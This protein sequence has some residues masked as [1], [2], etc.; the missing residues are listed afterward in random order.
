MVV[1]CLAAIAATWLLAAGVAQATVAPTRPDKDGTP[2]TVDDAMRMVLHAFDDV[3]ESNPAQAADGLD[4]A[5]HAPGFAGL[6]E[7]LRLQAISVAGLL[8]WEADRNEKAHELAVQATGFPEADGTSWMLRFSSAFS[9]GKFQDAGYSL[10]QFAKRWPARLDDVVP[11]AVF[12]LH[13]QLK[14]AR[15]DATDR[16]MLDELFDAK[17]QNKGVEPSYLWRD[18]ALTHLER[19]E[20]ARATEVALRVTSGEVALAMQVDKRF[21]PVTLSHRDAFDVDRL[22]AAEIAAASAQIQAH[23]DQLQPVTDLQELLLLT[24]RYPEVLS[25]SD[26]AVASAEKRQGAKTYSD[27]GE[28][29]N[30]ILDN[31][32]R[33]YKRQ[34]QWQKAIA[35]EALAARLPENGGINVSQAINLGQLYAELGQPDNA[36]NAIIQLGDLSPI[37]QMQLEGVKLRIAI[38]RHDDAAALA[39]MDYLHKH[40][41]EEP[42]SWQDALLLR[43]Q[44]EDAAAFLIERLRN[45]AWRNDALVGIQHYAPMGETP[46]AKTLG[47]RLQKVVARSDVQA[48]VQ[49]VG[50]IGKF[51]IAPG[52]R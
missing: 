45:P 52:L 49:K 18:L 14:L 23:P 21:D 17:W 26:A 19:G 34:G 29:Y 5:M 3:R 6:S 43:G 15:E 36:A 37:G 24:G 32:S 50:R 40:R 51:N 39:V 2:A 11:G 7:D 33:A 35:T 25:I 22:V 31:R 8:A 1:K 41:A 9:I 13:Y 27:F 44:L 42:D 28:R 16:E 48:A 4:K 46:M 12:Q 38:D 10:A 20:T 47:E 30:W